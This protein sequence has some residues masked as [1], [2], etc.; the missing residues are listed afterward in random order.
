M[1]PSISGSGIL[2]NGTFYQNQG[3]KQFHGHSDYGSEVYIK[4]ARHSIYSS[5]VYIHQN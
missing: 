3:K 2:F 1:V 5:D 4:F